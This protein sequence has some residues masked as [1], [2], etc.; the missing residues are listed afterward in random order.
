VPYENTKNL[1]INFVAFL[2][3]DLQHIHTEFSNGEGWGDELRM[4][5]TI[6]QKLDRQNE[7]DER[8]TVVHYAFG[9]SYTDRFLDDYKK[10]SKLFLE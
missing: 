1:S 6:P 4:C 2:G 10:L 9:C 7:I 8:F 3:R 5:Q